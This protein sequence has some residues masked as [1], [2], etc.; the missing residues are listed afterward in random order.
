MSDKTKYIEIEG[1]DGSTYAGKAVSALKMKTKGILGDDLL[2]FTLLDFVDFILLN[3]KFISNGFIITDE[4]KEEQY[5][6]I[7]ESG[8]EL[9]IEDLERFIQLKDNIKIIKSK[10]E[11]Y[12]SLIEKL[13][14]LSDYN[15]IESVNEIVEK[16]LRR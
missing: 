16:Y 3:N 15:D 1:I 5:I 4:N 13:Q 8:E 12:F 10:K 9:L 6:K 11:E 7:I 14:L 2:I